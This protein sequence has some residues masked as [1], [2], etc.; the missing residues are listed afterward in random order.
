MG[1]AQT[2]AL[3]LIAMAP[4]EAP[5]PPER[6]V[7][8]ATA[9]EADDLDT[10]LRDVRRL[11][12]GPS[13]GPAP[14]APADTA[15]EVSAPET[16]PLPLARA[17]DAVPVE[18]ADA[19]EEAPEAV[20]EAAMSG[21]AEP[22]EAVAAPENAPAPP[23]RP[24]AAETEASV[25]A[26]RTTLALPGNRRAGRG[27]VICGD[28][29]L[30]GTAIPPVEDAANRCRI[31]EPVRVNA[32]SGV[33]LSSAAT[34][35]CATASRF[36]SWLTGIAQ[37]AA[38]ETLGSP[39][40][41]VWVMASYVCRTRNNSPGARL[42]EHAFGRAVDV[43]GVWLADGRQITVAG[44][45]GKDADGRF[46][47]RIRGRACGLFGTVLGPG[48]DQHHADHFHLDTAG[49]REPYCR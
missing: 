37:P 28:P 12:T 19:E 47:S 35:D 40:E 14:A 23:A 42:S 26:L 1:A 18:A 7:P 49:R 43:G 5:E 10:L 3:I 16:A 39:I 41:R 15:A 33:A 24:E 2:I 44:D 34:L 21:T 22:P 6:A 8:P 31:D 27:Q 38:R 13:A 45:W 32:I 11:Y 20:E 29:R 17:A 46:L 25:P 4:A 9:G 48:A 36:A 30:S